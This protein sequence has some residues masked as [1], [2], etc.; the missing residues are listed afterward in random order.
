MYILCTH[1]FPPPFPSRSRSWQVVFL[2][3]VIDQPRHWHPSARRRAIPK[4]SGT[5]GLW[6]DVAA[7]WR[8]FGRW[9]LYGSSAFIA[10]ACVYL[11]TIYRFWYMHSAPVLAQLI[12][13]AHESCLYHLVYTC[14]LLSAVQTTQLTSYSLDLKMYQSSWKAASCCPP[15]N[16]QQSGLT[17]SMHVSPSLGSM[18][19]IQH[20]K[21]SAHQRTIYLINFLRL[22]TDHLCS[23]P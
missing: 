9:C 15:P 6:L 4:A 17:Q 14:N 19:H 2:S 16:L 13:G 10:R 12:Y 7:I 22:T 20:M 18:K 21:Y 23:K 1:W 3:P 5:W 8:M 11:Y